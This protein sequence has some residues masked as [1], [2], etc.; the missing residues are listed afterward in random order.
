MNIKIDD[1]YSIKSDPRNVILVENK[2]VQD[3]DRKGEVYETPVSY[4]GSV[5]EALKSYKRMRINTSEATT[6]KEL[7][8]VVKETD[9]KIDEVLKGI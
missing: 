1:N 3:G 9:R 6:I 7:L 2:I 8:S 5:T 4:H